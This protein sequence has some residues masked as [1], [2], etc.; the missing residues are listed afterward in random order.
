MLVRI[1][2]RPQREN[3]MHAATALQNVVAH[4]GGGFGV[5]LVGSQVALPAQQFEL[6]G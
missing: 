3:G 6:P 5:E 4:L 2:A 1:G